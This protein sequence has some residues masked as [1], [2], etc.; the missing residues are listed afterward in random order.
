MLPGTLYVCCA[1]LFLGL[2]ARVVWNYMFSV[3]STFSV[4]FCLLIMC[5]IGACGLLVW[6]SNSSRLVILE[7]PESH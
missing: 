7:W 4:I 6:S 5:G 1:G 2:A 3:R